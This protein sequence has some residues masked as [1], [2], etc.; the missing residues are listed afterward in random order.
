MTLEEIL[1]LRPSSGDSNTIRAALAKAELTR[2]DLGIQAGALQAAR[3]KGL[4]VVSD[5]ELLQAEKDAAA[6]RLAMER[7]EAIIPLIREDLAKAEAEETLT[8]LREGVTDVQAKVAALEAWQKNQFPKLT[9]I[10][11]EGFRLQ[12]EA[13]TARDAYLE[14]V[15][16]E[17]SRPEIRA[18]GELGVSIPQM[19]GNLPREQ[20]P[21]W[22]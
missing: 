18:A 12:D 3:N 14:R 20:F 11:A 6:A 13:K 8:S 19:P 22:R 5:E 1:A 10:M 7:I 15:R 21:N 9:A 2:N 17:Y 16:G 4:L